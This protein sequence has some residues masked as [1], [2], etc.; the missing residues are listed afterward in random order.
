MKRANILANTVIALLVVVAAA[1]I[2]CKFVLPRSKTGSF[3]IKNLNTITVY[4]LNENP[5][6]FDRPA[7]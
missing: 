1:L 2:I 5:L 4:D 3:E 6:K 7:G